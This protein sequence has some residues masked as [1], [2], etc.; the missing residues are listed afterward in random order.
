MRRSSL[1]SWLWYLLRISGAALVALALV[2]LAMMHYAHAP[3]ATGAAFVAARWA[4]A[5]WRWFDWALLVLALVHGFGGLYGIVSESMRGVA[6]RLLRALV[7]AATA[8]FVA[9]GSAA[10]AAGAPAAHSGGST[11]IAGVLAG[12]LIALATLSYLAAA[13]AIAVLALRVA[14]RTP[15]GRWEIPGQ[16]A[17]GLHRLSGVAILAFLAIHVFDVALAPFAP[18]AYDATVAAYGIPYLVPME[19]AL[20][21][22]VLYHSLNG[23]RL[24]LLEAL[25]QRAQRLEAPLFALAIAL[26]LIALVPAAL[27][28]ALG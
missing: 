23:L 5:F 11:S 27:V 18:A 7:V 24:M 12:L 16:W 8:V 25:P 20:V 21:G 14:R 6:A 3:S 26:T 22:A 17:W 13:L 28:I 2:H 15:I 19:L 9:L 1:A 4:H 10:V